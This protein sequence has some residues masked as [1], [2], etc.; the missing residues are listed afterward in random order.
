[1]RPVAKSYGTWARSTNPP[2][3]QMATARVR[4]FIIWSIIR[5]PRRIWLCLTSMLPSTVGVIL[6]V[7]SARPWQTKNSMN[8]ENATSSRDT[9]HVGKSTRNSLGWTMLPR[10][11]EPLR[12]WLLRNLWL[13]R[14]NSER[15]KRWRGRDMS[16]RRLSWRRPSKSRQSKTILTRSRR[17]RWR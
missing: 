14:R 5:V 13:R 9:P 2:S 8:F 12:P 11:P 7:K 16:R 3:I 15:R 4:Y 17:V 6:Q 1:M 10:L